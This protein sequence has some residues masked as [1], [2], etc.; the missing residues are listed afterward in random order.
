M[1]PIKLI[2]GWP[3]A[4]TIDETGI[5]NTV[6]VDCTTLETPGNIGKNP[7]ESAPN[8]SLTGNAAIFNANDAEPTADKIA[9]VPQKYTIDFIVHHIGKGAN[10]IYITRWYGYGLADITVE[11]L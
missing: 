8:E 6:F 11:P 9:E 2:E 5:R 10:V 4:V 1:G 3:S 7:D